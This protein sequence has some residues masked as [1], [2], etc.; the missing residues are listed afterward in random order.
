[1]FSETGLFPSYKKVL[2]RFSSIS[3][4]FKNRSGATKI[5]KGYAID[6]YVLAILDNQI[7]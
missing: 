4:N 7:A 1:M 2:N 6:V 5:P 3:A